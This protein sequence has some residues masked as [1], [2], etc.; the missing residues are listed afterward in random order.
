[1]SYNGSV[2]NAEMEIDLQK[3][4]FAYLRRWWVFVICAAVAGAIAL[5]YTAFF[6]TPMYSSSITVYVNNSNRNIESDYVAGSDISASKAL[7]NTYMAIAESNRFAAR[8]ADTLGGNYTGARVQG[9]MSIVGV[10]NTELFKVVISSSNPEVAVA[11]ARVVGDTI[12]DEISSI[13]EGS[14]AHVIDDPVLA[15]SPYTPSYS[16]NVMVGVL[17]GVVLAAAYLTLA[18]LFD[19][20][21]KDED[22]LTAI[23]DFPVLGRVP[24]LSDRESGGYEE[25]GYKR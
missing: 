10:E 16:R 15:T 12:P 2:Q 8:V 13:V 18:F 24:T 9:M 1:M 22:D 23:S 7:V 14:S 17:V 20:R 21:I 3:L 11:V 5:G 19:V 25:G 4:L 6:V